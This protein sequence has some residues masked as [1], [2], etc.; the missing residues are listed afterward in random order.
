M[1][2]ITG[3]IV[4]GAIATIVAMYLMNKM[5]IIEVV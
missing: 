2:K 3:T 5:N 4:M 1:S